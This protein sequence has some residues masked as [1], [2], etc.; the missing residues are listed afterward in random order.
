MSTRVSKTIL[1]FHDLPLGVEISGVKFQSVFCGDVLPVFRV[2]EAH[3]KNFATCLLGKILQFSLPKTDAKRTTFYNIDII[4]TENFILSGFWVLLH[5]HSAF[6]A[7]TRY[8]KSFPRSDKSVKNISRLSNVPTTLPPPAYRFC[9]TFEFC[10]KSINLSMAIQNFANV[11]GSP[12]WC[13]LGRRLLGSAGSQQVRCGRV[14]IL[15]RAQYR[16]S[17]FSYF[18]VNCQLRKLIAFLWANRSALLF[19]QTSLALNLWRIQS[20]NF[21]LGIAGYCLR[22]A[23][24]HFHLIVALR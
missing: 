3:W 19:S 14:W 4:S 21:G 11:M 18:W 2:S 12:K 23:A 1:C 16:A 20:L 5:N 13:L 9:I 24:S 7:I 8:P 15:C 22:E 10:M 17:S 6:W